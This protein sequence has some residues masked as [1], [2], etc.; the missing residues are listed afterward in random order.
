M[1]CPECGSSEV[2]ASRSTRW[3]DFFQRVRGREAFRCRKCRQRFFAS[4]S[5]ESGSKPTA[6]STHTHRPNKLMSTRSKKRLVRQL[7]VAVIFA[8]AFALFLFFLRYLTTDRMPTT[9]Y[10]AGKSSLT[11]FAA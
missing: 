1:T 7:I 6:Q 5:S 8:V 10:G 9:D 4:P 2:R 11:F 3:N